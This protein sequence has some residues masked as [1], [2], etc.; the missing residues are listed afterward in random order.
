MSNLYA[1]ADGIAGEGR[2]F[3]PAGEARI[4]MIDPRDV[5]AAAAVTLTTSG[6]DGQTYVLTG[7]KAITYTQVATEL[8]AAIG[9]QVD[10]VDMPDE[11]ARHGMIEAGGLFEPAAVGR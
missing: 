7:P 2:L 11:G 3:A 10:F 1:A 9:R 8:S 4:A 5:G 6:H